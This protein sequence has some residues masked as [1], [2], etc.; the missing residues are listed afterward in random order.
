MSVG[1]S[2]Q[3]Y[4]SKLPFPSQRDLPDPGIKPVSLASLALGG[5]FFTTGTTWEAQHRLKE[6]V[7]HYKSRFLVPTEGVED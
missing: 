3:E 6:G 4:W 2:R 1:F 7:S 5:G